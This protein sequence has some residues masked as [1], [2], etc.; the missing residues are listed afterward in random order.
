MA[1]QR[2]GGRR[3][4]RRDFVQGG[5]AGGLILAAPAVAQRRQPTAES[6]MGPFYPVERPADSDADLTQVIGRAGRAQGTIIELR[7]RVLDMRGRPI[8]MAT[9][10]LWQANAAGRYDHPADPATAPL[11]ANFQG[12]ASVRTDAQGAWRIITVKP[13]GYDSP[14][15]HRPPHI[16]FD[17]MGN[18][19]R[20]IAQL[21]FPEEAGNATDALYRALG[22]QAASS[23]AARDA[24]NPNLY[25]WDVVMMEG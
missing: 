13:G 2:H 5:L 11:D 25:S 20:N 1:E 16:H 3:L 9:V 17:I 10:A 12:F 7:G 22:D 23:V 15:G 6:P 24:A 21:Y 4:T 8:P 19:H 14:V 18:Q